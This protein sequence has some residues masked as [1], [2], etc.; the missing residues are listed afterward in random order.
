M[1]ARISKAGRDP[2]EP[3]TTGSFPAIQ[4]DSNQKSFVAFGKVPIAPM[5]PLGNVRYVV[6]FG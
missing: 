2:L 6:G 5:L 3:F 4:F 1:L